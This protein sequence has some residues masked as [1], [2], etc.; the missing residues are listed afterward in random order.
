MSN[1]QPAPISG[2][3]INQILHLETH[4]NNS[5]HV[6]KCCIAGLGN[7]L[8]MALFWCLLLYYYE[9]CARYEGK[10]PNHT[11]NFTF[12]LQISHSWRFGAGDT[13]VLADGHTNPCRTYRESPPTALHIH[14]VWTKPCEY[15]LPYLTYAFMYQPDTPVRMNFTTC[16][17]LRTLRSK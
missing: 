14:T 2:N 7:S 1:S 10:N 9:W 6:D 15:I 17:A 12:F 11:H 5:R 3:V 13:Y 16:M 4:G 8:N